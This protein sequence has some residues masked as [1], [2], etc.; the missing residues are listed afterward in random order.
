MSS[1]F[2]QPENSV[3]HCRKLYLSYF[4]S[5]FHVCFLL[6]HDFSIFLK[7]FFLATLPNTFII[8]VVERSK[9]F[10]LANKLLQFFILADK[11]LFF[12][13]ILLV[14]AFRLFSS[15]SHIQYVAVMCHATLSALRSEQKSV[16]CVFCVSRRRE[17]FK[18]EE[19]LWLS[20]LLLAMKFYVSN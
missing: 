7:I 11:P 15:F 12:F 13:P 8:G 16:S 17:E 6:P 4:F 10:F 5:T 18:C 1:C 2:Y 19:F 20:I 14:N 3:L 9:R